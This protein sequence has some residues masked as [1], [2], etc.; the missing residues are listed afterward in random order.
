MC[1]YY[2]KAQELFTDIFTTLTLKSLI[3]N[4]F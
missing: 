2:K 3:F 1:M 4:I